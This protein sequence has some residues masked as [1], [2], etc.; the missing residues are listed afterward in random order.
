MRATRTSIASESGR[1]SRR[2]C[3]GATSNRL[4]IGRI[5][6]SDH[7]VAVTRVEHGPVLVLRAIILVVVGIDMTPDRLRLRVIE[8]LLV[9]RTYAVGSLLRVFFRIIRRER[10]QAHRQ[11]VSVAA[12][13]IYSEA[14]ILL[15][16][17][18]SRVRGERLLL[19]FT[20]AR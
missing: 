20:L 7:E 17:W 12:K 15:A 1:S 4:R 14:N 2:R 9:E 10:A 13:V 8:V 6:L 3:H 16:L 19:S 18:I 11:T 5:R